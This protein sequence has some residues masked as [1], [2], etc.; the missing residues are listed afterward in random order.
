MKWRRPLPNVDGD[1]EAD[2]LDDAPPERARTMKVHPAWS[3]CSRGCGTSLEGRPMRTRYCLP[4]AQQLRN[5]GHRKRD[6]NR[7]SHAVPPRPRGSDPLPPRRPASCKR[8]C[9]LPWAREPDREADQIT[10][11]FGTGDYV[12]VAMNSTWLCVGCGKPW[13]PEPAPERGVGISSSAGTAVAA[14]QFN[15]MVGSDGG[16][17]RMAAEK[18]GK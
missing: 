1:P 17:A 18:E 8:C 11:R 10:S 6:P 5:F 4:C 12:G 2:E 9:D 15:G 7:P 13:A 14:A 3:R 16:R